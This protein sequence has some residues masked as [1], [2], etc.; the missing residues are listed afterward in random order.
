MKPTLIALLT[1][2]VACSK[3]KDGESDTDMLGS[4]ERPQ[5]GLDDLST[6]F[7]PWTCDVQEATGATGPG[8]TDYFYGVFMDTADGFTGYE[9]WHLFAN[10]TWAAADGRDCV[11]RWNVEATSSD[12]INC[13]GCDMKLDV[14]LTLDESCTT[15]PESLTES[16][17]G[18]KFETYEVMRKSD[19]TT[20][21]FF[22]SSNTE[23]GQ[24]TTNNE[25]MNFATDRS[26]RWF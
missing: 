12:P 11:M 26:C 20:R 9:E 1:L 19:G 5:Y 15:C 18:S 10:E 17:E 24:G 14:V 6:D 23:F 21:W 3:T 2:G 16:E 25:A 8:A 4:C 13:G 22:S 7:E